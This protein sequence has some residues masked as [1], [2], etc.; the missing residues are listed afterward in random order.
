MRLIREALQTIVLAVLIFLVLQTSFQ[1]FQVKGAS[2]EPSLHNKQY[3]MVNKVVYLHVRLGKAA[4]LVPF[5]QQEGDVVYLFHPP[6]RGEVVVFHPPGNP[7]QDYI[8][9]VI[10]L[11]GE[12]VAVK[13][14]RVFIDGQPL[15]EWNY[16][17][18]APFYTLESQRIPPGHYFVL[19]DNRN[20]SSDSHSWGTVPYQ[21]IV[22]KAWISFWPLP[23]KWAP[24]RS[25]QVAEE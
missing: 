8:K 3:L 15:E 19:G 7:Q 11:P 17:R 10:G 22:G 13:D 4:K 9:R 5:L 25:T 16:V 18:Q 24:N 21:N 6:R 20:S 2:M 14:R 12:T 23:P 1:S